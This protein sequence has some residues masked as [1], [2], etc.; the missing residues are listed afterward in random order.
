MSKKSRIVFLFVLL[1]AA[2]KVCISQS[3]R[4]IFSDIGKTKVFKIASLN[5]HDSLS[6]QKT[7]SNFLIPLYSKGFITA[8]IDS[9]RCDSTN[10]HAYGRIGDRYR[11][12]KVVPDSTTNILFNE[13][14][15]NLPKLSGKHV[16][17]K[18][19]TRYINFS[20]QHFEDNGYPF[21]RVSLNKVIIDDRF[22][23]SDKC[24]HGFKFRGFI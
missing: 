11:W 24:F 4:V 8:S 7:L 13:I 5:C 22:S 14:G 6:I 17:P 15:I 10:L 2:Q 3:L 18:L 19:L 23:G 12:V 16:S 20:L 21:A 9:F 1:L